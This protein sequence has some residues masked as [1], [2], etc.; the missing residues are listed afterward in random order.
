VGGA[1][2]TGGREDSKGKMGG[3][4]RGGKRAGR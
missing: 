2:G 1:C 4:R 3:E